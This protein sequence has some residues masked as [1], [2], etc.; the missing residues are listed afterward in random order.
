MLT[1]SF[2]IV[3]AKP[4][5]FRGKVFPTPSINPHKRMT[6]PGLTNICDNH[7]IQNVKMS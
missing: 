7:A 6:Q 4:G 1:E 5:D 3:F 2:L